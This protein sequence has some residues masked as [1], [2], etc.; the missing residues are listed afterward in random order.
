M[1][2]R[3][4]VLVPEDL[5]RQVKASAAIR[6]ESISDIVREA[7][8]DYVASTLAEEEDF[9]EAIAAYERYRRDPTSARPYPEIRAELVAEGLIR[10]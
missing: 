8:E 7:L 10:E 4:S 1:A 9:G 3:L 5:R 2:V 6:G